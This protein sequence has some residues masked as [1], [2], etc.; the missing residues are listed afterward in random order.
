MDLIFNV[1]YIILVGKLTALEEWRIARNDLMKKFEIQEQ[2][3]QEQEERH[4]KQLY[5]VERNLII[6]KAE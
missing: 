2:N 4:K 6:S 3:I 5:E 1:I